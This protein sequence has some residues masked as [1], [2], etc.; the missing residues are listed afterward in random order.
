MELMT[1]TITGGSP[2]VNIITLGEELL[3]SDCFLASFK[4]AW[5]VEPLVFKEKCEN[6][7][8]QNLGQFLYG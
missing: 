4:L 1:G 2:K 6:S 7:A 5:T 3:T 8:I